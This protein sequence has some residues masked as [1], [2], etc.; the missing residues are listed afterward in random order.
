M[1]SS[2]IFKGFFFTHLCCLCVKWLNL[3]ISHQSS[4]IV[5][6]SIYE[7]CGKVDFFLAELNSASDTVACWA[8]CQEAPYI[9]PSWEGGRCHLSKPTATKALFFMLEEKVDHPGIL[10]LG[11]L[12]CG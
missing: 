3:R 4:H 11:F 9:I 7:Q 10:E 8:G 6:L 12:P 2:V 1:K 5:L